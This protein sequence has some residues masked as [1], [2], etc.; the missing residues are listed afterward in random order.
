MFTRRHQDKHYQLTLLLWLASL[1]YFVDAQIETNI[2]VASVTGDELMQQSYDRHQQFPYIYEEQSL[3]MED[4]NG[5]RDT[6][7]AIRYT[8]AEQDGSIKFLLIFDYP[9]EIRGVALLAERNPDGHYTRHV[10]LPALGEIMKE[11]VGSAGEGNFLGTDFSVESLT[12]EDLSRY[13]YVRRK[14]H[15]IDGIGFHVLDVYEKMDVY[16]KTDLHQKSD[17]YAKTEASNKPVRR[18]F[19]R[20]DSLYITLTHHYDRLGRV[21][22]IQSQHDLRPVAGNIWRADMM[23]MVDKKEDHQSLIKIS[24]RVYSKDYVPEE[25]FTAD[26]LFKQY[27]YVEPEIDLDFKSESQS[28]S[29]IDQAEA[30]RNQKLASMM[31]AEQ[32][33]IE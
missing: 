19:I 10:Y 1:S 29:D 11:T 20:Q 26:W 28:E 5:H 17:V 9:E 7:R 12:G 18:H 16:E 27:P 33:P 22:R 23:L 21:S 13:H 8:R 31:L 2:L 25:V 6:R 32:E 4:S 24:R 30:I 3:V 14:D 15:E